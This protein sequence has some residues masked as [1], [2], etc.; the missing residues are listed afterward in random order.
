MEIVV[1]DKIKQNPEWDT[2]AY[3]AS[4]ML[5]E[6]LKDRTVRLAKAEWGLI[7]YKDRFPGF[8]L[9]VTDELGATAEE[10]F[11][12]EELK[13]GRVLEDRLRWFCD[14][15]LSANLHKLLA[16]LHQTVQNLEED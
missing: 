10:R 12:L 9:R 7:W 16:R 8:L 15:V 13:D 11:S 5:E 6:L 14:K 1:E 3:G 2:A 4:K